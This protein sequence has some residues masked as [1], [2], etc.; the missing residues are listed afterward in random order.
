MPSIRIFRLFLALLCVLCGHISFAY[1]DKLPD[2]VS[3]LADKYGIPVDAIS[4]DVHD[5][6][7]GKAIL[8]VN[9]EKPR[10]PASVIKLLTTLSALEL[11]GPDYVWNTRY[12]IEGKLAGDVIQGDLVLQGGGDPFLTVDRLWHQVL[13]IRGRGIRAINGSLV[14]DWISECWK[15]GVEFDS[16]F[17]LVPYF[18]ALDA[19]LAT[20]MWSMLAASNEPGAKDL[21]RYAS[22]RARE[23]ITNKYTLRGR[24][25]V[26]TLCCFF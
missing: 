14:I 19:K 2:Q 26:W 15:D 23:A 18:M 17:T 12:F 24:Q 13:S 21:S 7:S 9:S 8:Q 3:N 20:A 11:L 5:L 25:L 4:I 6:S 22:T 10:N 16:L 1:G